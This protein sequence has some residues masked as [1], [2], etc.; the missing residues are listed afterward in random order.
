[1]EMARGNFPPLELA[2]ASAPLEVAGLVLELELA[3]AR[4]QVRC[5]QVRREQVR[6]HDAGAF[7]LVLGVR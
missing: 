7:V 4:E 1:M 5:E 2:R 3:S 6:Q